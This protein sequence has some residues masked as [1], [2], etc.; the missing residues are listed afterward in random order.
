MADLERIAPLSG[1]VPTPVGRDVGSK[2]Q[3]PPQPP[4]RPASDRTAE[5]PRQDGPGP[6][7]IDE[8]V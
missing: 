6:D 8:Y 5:T 2:R 7:H 1:T 4:R 3:R